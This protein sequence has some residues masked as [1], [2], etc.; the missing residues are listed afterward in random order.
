MT[1]GARST[2][3]IKLIFNIAY[4]ANPKS[5]YINIFP[6]ICHFLLKRL[7]L[8][9]ILKRILSEIRTWISLIKEV[10]DQMHTSNSSSKW[11]KQKRKWS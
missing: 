2:G 11:V 9:Y 10:K 3:I 6:Q 7:T 5:F 1:S 8:F 4:Q